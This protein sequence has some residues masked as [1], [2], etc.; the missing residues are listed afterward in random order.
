MD[1]YEILGV[2]KNASKD[3]IKKAFR[4]KARQYHPDVNK[5]PDAEEKYQE[6]FTLY[7]QMMLPVTLRHILP[8]GMVGL[9]AL[10]ILLMMLSTDDSRLFSAAQ[11]ITQD[12]VIP[13][14]GSNL[15]TEK[16]VFIIKIVSIICGAFWFV[17]SFFMAQL[18]YINMFVTIMCSMWIGAGPMVF[19]GLYS[20]FGNTKGA[21]T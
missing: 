10:F 15:T 4:Q 3:E 5:A 21:F 14:M 17:G 11:T 2:E 6:F 1:Y 20:R 12:C 7:H 16:H 9:F 18:D 13:F 19:F 8:V